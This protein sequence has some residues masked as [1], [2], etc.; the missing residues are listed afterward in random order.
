MLLSDVPPCFA[1][2]D[3]ADCHPTNAKFLREFLPRN[4]PYGKISANGVNLGISQ[5]C[6]RMALALRRTALGGHIA[7]VISL[8]AKP[9]M[10]NA[11]RIVSARTVVEDEQTVPD[12][13]VLQFVGKAMSKNILAVNGTKPAVAIFV[14]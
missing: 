9:E 5:L 7:Q 6:V 4:A 11:G 3:I 12:W 10:F 1:A 14:G 2:N 8:R 13:A